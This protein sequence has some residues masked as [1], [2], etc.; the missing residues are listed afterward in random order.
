MARLITALG[1]RGVG[2]VAAE[3]IKDSYSD[4]DSLGQASQES[5]K[6]ID[7]IGEVVANDI[8]AWVREGDNQKLLA[9]FNAIGL[10]LNNEL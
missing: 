6:E 10:W 8:H 4:L 5:L 9:K 2:E 3:K 1:N 7:G